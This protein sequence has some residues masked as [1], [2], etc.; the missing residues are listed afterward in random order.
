[1][2]DRKRARAIFEPSCNLCD[3]GVVGNRELVS[4]CKAVVHAGGK[5][6]FIRVVVADTVREVDGW[7]SRSDSARA[8]LGVKKRF[9]Y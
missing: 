5:W 4:V 2:A 1:M 3:S 6:W 8:K 9:A 7:C